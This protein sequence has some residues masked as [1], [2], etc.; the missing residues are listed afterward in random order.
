LGAYG[1]TAQLIASKLA[2]KN[3]VFTIA[4]RDESKLIELQKKYSQ[5]SKY[6][7]IDIDLDDGLFSAI[8]KSDL[9]INCIG[10]YNIYGDKILEKCINAGVCYID[11]CG[12]QYFI[13]KT[14]E[15]YADK[16]ASSGSGVIHSIAFESTLVDL[17]AELYLPKNSNWD[18]ISSIYY[19][20]KSRP[21]PGTKI[22]MQTSS[23]FPTFRV[24]N[25]SF[26][27]SRIS[28][29]SKKV[30]NST[31]PD[32]DALLFAPYP[33]ILFFKYRYAPR[34]SN[35]Y[36]LTNQVNA[37]YAVLDNF[38]KPTLEVLMEQNKKRLINVIDKSERQN[39]YFEIMLYAIDS[40]GKH[41]SF[42]II[43]KDMYELTISIMATYIEQLIQYENLPTGIL[44][45][46]DINDPLNIFQ[47]IVNQNNLIVKTGCDLN[48][49]DL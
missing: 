41:Y 46:S 8:Q 26:N 21:S 25:Y 39:Q 28:S 10:P 22:S 23:Y 18:E 49:L 31:R 43:G 47:Q 38:P 44:F 48:I 36:I 5:I 15:Q 3:I 1:Y 4:G 34:Y 11:I 40:D 9:V 19:F 27:E 32:F 37:K 2:E 29:F 13:Y 30:H 12:E 6:Y 33:E 45:P 16:I 24:N 35:S 42:S 7:V 20:E 14:L 17:L